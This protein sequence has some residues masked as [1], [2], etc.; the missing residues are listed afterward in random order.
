MRQALIVWENFQIIK[1]FWE[2]FRLLTQ[3][4]TFDINYIQL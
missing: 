2:T 4:Y 1:T 3:S